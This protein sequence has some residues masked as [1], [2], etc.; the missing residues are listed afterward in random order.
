M[1]TSRDQYLKAILV[2]M[3][4][5]LLSEHVFFLHDN[6]APRLLEQ[7]EDG[8]HDVVDVAETRRLRLLG[9]VESSRPVDGD[10]GLLLVKLHRARW[11]SMK[12]FKVSLWGGDYWR[13][14]SSVE[15]THPRSRPWRAGRTQTSRQTPD[16][17]LPH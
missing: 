10:V 8:E 3:N 11:K 7:L 1:K 12:I 16:S 2:V 9:V 6:A 5:A 14:C 15:Q 17:L 13:M 4:T